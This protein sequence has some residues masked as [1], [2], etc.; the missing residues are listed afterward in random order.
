M[1]IR[2]IPKVL[3]A[4]IDLIS[5]F[6]LIPFAERCEALSGNT[7]R[8]PFLHRKIGSWLAIRTHFI[9]RCVFSYS[10]LLFCK[11]YFGCSRLSLLRLVAECKRNSSSGELNN[12]HKPAIE[13]MLPKTCIAVYSKIISARNLMYVMEY[14]IHDSTW[15][16]TIMLLWIRFFVTLLTSLP[17]EHAEQRRGKGVVA[18]DS[19]PTAATPLSQSGK[20]RGRDQICLVSGV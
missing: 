12:T 14:D 5:K 10:K 11:N 9:Q 20:W 7:L 1:R 6:S 15:L 17:S 3:L 2:N 8:L 13:G 16:E 4:N 19:C 18:D